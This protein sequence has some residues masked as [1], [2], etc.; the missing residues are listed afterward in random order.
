M[1]NGILTLP[2]WVQGS[3]SFAKILCLDP[4][5]RS[6]LATPLE[7]E[8]QGWISGCIIWRENICQI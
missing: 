3:E 7:D 4:S 5:S 1:A 8:H 6:Q 2:P